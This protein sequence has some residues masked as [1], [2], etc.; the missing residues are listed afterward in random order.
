MKSYQQKLSYLWLSVSLLGMNVMIDAT[1]TFLTKP[2]MQMEQT[3]EYLYK[4]LSS[5]DWKKS[6]SGLFVV[7]PK[8]DKDFIH[9]SKD[10][11]VDRIIDKY[12]KTQSEFVILKVKTDHLPGTLVYEAN[13]GGTNKYYHLYA[14]SI[15]LKAIVGIEMRKN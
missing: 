1:E 14:G 12:W 8:E 5:E 6:E 2:Q 9:L 15:P 7:I 10:D 11:Q 4:I 13:P 3:P